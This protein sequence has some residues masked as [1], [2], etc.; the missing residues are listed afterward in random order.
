MEDIEGR[1]SPP[2][3]EYLGGKPSLTANREIG[4]L[5][6]FS[7]AGVQ[8]KFGAGKHHGSKGERLS[9]PAQGLGGDWIVKLP[10]PQHDLL[11]ENEYSMMTLAK[12]IGINVPDFGLA[13]TNRV[14]GIPEEFSNVDSSAYYIKRF[15][16]TAESRIHIEDFN[17]IFGQFP[18]QKYDNQSYNTI[19]KNIH[20][21]LGEADYR[22]FVR[23][24]VFSILIGN[25]DMH[26][27]NWSVVYPDGRTPKLSPAYDFVSTIVYPRIDKTLPLSFAGTKYAEEIDEDLL[28][29]FA[30]KTEA[31]HSYVLETANETVRNFKDVWTSRS[32]DLPLRK[33]WREMITTRPDTLPLTKLG[34]GEITPKK[35][36]GRPG[37]HSAS[38]G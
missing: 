32:K 37:R 23:R 17:Q 22:E 12:E 24:L 38:L 21:I 25:M 33:D 20:R 35:R 29:S 27:K 34:S 16:R 3:S 18:A 10:S 19:G 11:P 8:L 6:R 15:D 14:E 5:P 30:A 7:L 26:L 36:R 28:A 1:P 9:I 2:L 13:T 4:P 31:P